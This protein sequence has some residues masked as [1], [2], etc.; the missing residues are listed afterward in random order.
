ML[1][2]CHTLAGALRVDESLY[3]KGDRSARRS[4]RTC[5][6]LLAG[7]AGLP[8]PLNGPGFEVRPRNI[9]GSPLLTLALS[10]SLMAGLAALVFVACAGLQ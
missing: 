4:L 7:V 2:A 6:L 10:L 3:Q 1:R 9:S 8:G 5:S